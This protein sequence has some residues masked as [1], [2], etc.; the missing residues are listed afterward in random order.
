MLTFSDG[1]LCTRL[2]C[3]RAV[4]CRS[5]SSC[6]HPHWKSECRRG[7]QGVKALHVVCALGK[8]RL[9]AAAQSAHH[10]APVRSSVGTAA[11]LHA[12]GMQGRGPRLLQCKGQS[13]VQHNGC[14]AG[15]AQVRPGA[16]RPGQTLYVVPEACIACKRCWLHRSQSSCACRGWS[17]SC[18]RAPQCT[19]LVSVQDMVMFLQKAPTAY[20]ASVR[21]GGGTFLQEGPTAYSARVRAGDGH[22]SAKAPHIDLV[23]V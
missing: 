7:Q 1:I 13:R 20:S 19:V 9:P 23:R 4:C 3:G 16:A 11:A 8:E 22:V 14:G 15:P 2:I 12:Q 6:R 21:A 17:C 10:S 5:V 18:R